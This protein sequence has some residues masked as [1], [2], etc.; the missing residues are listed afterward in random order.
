[1]YPSEI[2]FRIGESIPLQNRLR[3][4]LIAKRG[5][6]TPGEAELLTTPE[7][8]SILVREVASNSSIQQKVQQAKQDDPDATIDT[9]IQAVPDSDLEYV[10][11]QTFTTLAA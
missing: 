7:A 2:A 4:V 10:A 9:A 1:M 5:I 11:G 3:G 6:C 8:L